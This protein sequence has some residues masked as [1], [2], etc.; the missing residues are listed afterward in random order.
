MVASEPLPRWTKVAATALARDGVGQG[1][2]G[3]WLEC[4]ARASGY[5]VA[6]KRKRSPLPTRL[7][8]LALVEV[9]ARIIL[10]ERLEETRDERVVW[11]HRSSANRRQEVTVPASDRPAVLFRSGTSHSKAVSW[12]G[13]AAVCC[14]VAARALRLEGGR[15][16]RRRPGGLAM[17]ARS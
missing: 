16:Y 2:F 7:S 1:D 6:W 5:R 15:A 9:A 8:H 12:I 14:P 11:C 17:I 3:L 13:A 10:A 4:F